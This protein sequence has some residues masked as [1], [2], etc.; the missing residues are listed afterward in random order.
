MRMN[1]EQVL[2]AKTIV[3]TYS[4]KVL[5]NFFQKYG[6]EP[7]AKLIAKNI[8]IARNNKEI[9]T[10]F[11]L[12][13]II[14]KTLPQ[15]ILKKAKHP[16]KRIFQALRIEVNKELFVLQESLRQA[17]TLLAIHGR[18]VVISFNSLE[19]RIVKKYFQNLTQDPN[20]EIN[21]QLP[22]MS[23]FKSN[24]RII[25][26]KAIIPS[27]IEQIINYRCTSAKLRILER[28]K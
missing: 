6:E 25:T 17:V 3:N 9:V 22:I 24:Y 18:L 7:F 14:K 2:T 19:D 21:Q 28:I 16:A 26:K 20:Y 23:N 27:M 11:Q 12:V 1:Q 13:E 8:V 5:T 4:Q 15:K 10:T